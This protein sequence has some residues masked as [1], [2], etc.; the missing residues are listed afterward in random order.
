MALETGAL[1]CAD[2]VPH[3]ARYCLVL[4][5]YAV[6]QD[7]TTINLIHDSLRESGRECESEDP[8]CRKSLQDPV[9]ADWHLIWPALSHTRYLRARRAMYAPRPL[10]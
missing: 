3:G 9:L 7:E 2:R 1:L 8:D 4:A 5:R 10:L 6:E